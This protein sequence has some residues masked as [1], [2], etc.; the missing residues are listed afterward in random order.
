MDN[1]EVTLQKRDQAT[2]MAEAEKGVAMGVFAS[3]PAKFWFVL[4]CIIVTFAIVAVIAL[5]VL[6]WEGRPH[7]R[8]RD[9][10]HQHKLHQRLA[11]M[12][13]ETLHSSV[14]HPPVA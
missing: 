2:Y 5:L 8:E 13:S 1:K 14:E 11:Q 4:L 3:D 7:A 9:E 6:G 10:I 12:T